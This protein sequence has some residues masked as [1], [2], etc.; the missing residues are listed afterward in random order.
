MGNFNKFDKGRD[1]GF[2]GGGFRG[3]RDEGRKFGGRSDAPRQMF[4]ATCGKCGQSC[5]VP[6]RPTAAFPV[7]CNNCFKSQ[8]G[9]NR[10]RASTDRPRFAPKSF[11]GNNG[12]NSFGGSPAG[13][14]AASPSPV[15]TKAQFDSL[16]VK[17]DKILALL[18]SAK[19]EEPA[20]EETKVQIAKTNKKI[21]KKAGGSAK[22]SKNKKK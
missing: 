6:F 15:V 1:R 19:L 18:T 4:P 7:F 5:E 10:G 9:D 16:N 20:K 11:G 14:M 22:K 12:G 17:L 3:G 8:K 21:V 13:N 2:G